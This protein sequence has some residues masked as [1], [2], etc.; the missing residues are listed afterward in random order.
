MAGGG[1][2]TVDPREIGHFDAM[3][4][5]WWEPEGQF[6]P[7]H[8][9][10]PARIGFI[11]DHACLAFDR[12]AESV[13]PLD[14][15]SVLDVGCGGGLLAEPMARL[16]GS[17][18]GIDAGAEA[19]AVARAHAEASGLAIDYA[20][21]TAEDLAASGE[22]FDLVLALEIVEHVADVDAFCRALS[23][24]VR[25][26]GLLVMSTLN[27]TA[28]SFA[29][30][31]AGAEYVLRLLPRGTHDWRRFLQPHELAHHLRRGGLSM[32]DVK[33]MVPDLRGGW[34]LSDR[35]LAVNYIVA[36]SAAG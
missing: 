33:G 12:D 31:I 23:R 11:R 15:L 26:G 14:G 28:K 32:R 34:R 10:N 2:T 7:L 25:P 18:T 24:L 3:A 8:R 29:A 30:A 16:G 13:T 4:G 35:R 27:R 21:R 9:M 1:E 6:R 17:V 20:V 19:I 5:Q 22:R 36:A